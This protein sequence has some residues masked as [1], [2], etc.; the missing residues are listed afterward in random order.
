[1]ALKQGVLNSSLVSSIECPAVPKPY[2]RGYFSEL[3]TLCSDVISL[4]TE[5]E[6]FCMIAMSFERR[7]VACEHKAGAC[8]LPY[9][10]VPHTSHA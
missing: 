3:C 7:R 9:Y 10:L 8:K 6:P 5:R 1:M 4:S 2:R